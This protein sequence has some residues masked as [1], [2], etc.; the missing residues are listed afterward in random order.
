[1]PRSRGLETGNVK[2]GF[3]SLRNPQTDISRSFYSV[4]YSVTLHWRSLS[5][6]RRDV[7]DGNHA[8][9]HLLINNRKIYIWSGKMLWIWEELENFYFYFQAL[10]KELCF[11]ENDWAECMFL[12]N[13]VS[14]TITVHYGRET[15]AAWLHP[16][17]ELIGL[18]LVSTL[19]LCWK[20]C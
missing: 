5:A 13:A 12:E 3:Y 19:F 9:A 17:W 6:V 2:G 10:K 7:N 11:G 14:V 4:K 8:T 15:I 1:M 18:C 16:S 20:A